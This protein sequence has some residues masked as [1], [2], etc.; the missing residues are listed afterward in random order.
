MSESDEDWK[1]DISDSP[2]E[3]DSSWEGSESRKPKTKTPATEKKTR[4]QPKPRGTTKSKL[5]VLSDDSDEDSLESKKPK[6]TKGKGPATAKNKSSSVIV[7]SDEESNEEKVTP[8]H[9]NKTKTSSTTASK[10]KSVGKIASAK[11]KSLASTLPVSTANKKQSLFLM[12]VDDSVDVTGDI[13]TIGVVQI[14]KENKK[15]PVQLDLKGMIF[16]CTPVR[17]NSFGV[18][19]ITSVGAEKEQHARITGITSSFL[20]CEKIDAQD[21]EIVFEGDMDVADEDIVAYKTSED[22]TA[23][24]K[25]DLSKPKGKRKTASSRKKGK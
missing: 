19:D 15:T 17:C 6:I 16:N 21:E 22:V 9:A 10:T 12:Q 18:V 8:E 4:K 3:S 11:R 5:T 2:E 7:I 13:A 1:E 20:S 25:I 14:N 24:K 23:K